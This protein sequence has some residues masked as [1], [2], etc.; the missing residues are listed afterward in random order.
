MLTDKKRKKLPLLLGVL[1]ILLIIGIFI[2]IRWV[3]GFQQKYSAEELGIQE[4]TS[5]LDMDKDGIDDYRDILEGARSYIQTKPDYDDEYV[6]GGYPNE[7][8]GVC[9]D[10]IW[11]ALAAAG[12]DLKQLVDEDILTY[13]DRYPAIEEPDPNIDFRRVRNLT[14]YF[15]AHS[16]V[17]TTDLENPA[18]WQAGDIVVFEGHIAICSDIRNASGIPF[19]LHH[20]PIGAREANDMSAYTIV[21][22]YRWNGDLI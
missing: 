7:G 3:P 5:P 16:D 19:I 6:I 18:D 4:I 9:T 11:Q 21:S 15:A 17:L 14:C 2:I 22:H 13:P 8:K 12:Y 20:G 10:V 1:S